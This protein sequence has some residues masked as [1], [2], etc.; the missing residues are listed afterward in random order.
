MKLKVS[1]ADFQQM[2]VEAAWAHGWKVAHFGVATQGDRHVTPCRY[3]AQGFPDLTL[4]HPGHG[5]VAFVELKVPP[6]GL[7]KHQEDWATWLESVE[8]AMR[9][10]NDCRR[11]RYF[12]WVPDSTERIV[13]WLT[14]PFQSAVGEGMG[15]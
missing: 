7:T 1:E 4:V 5:V 3:N 8:D 15:R 2:V 10:S 9:A 14:D 13:A 6:N 11:V 12:V